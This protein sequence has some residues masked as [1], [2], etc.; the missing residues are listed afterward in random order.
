VPVLITFEG[1]EGAGKSTLIRGLS[2]RLRMQGHEVVV[3][4]EPGAGEVGRRIREILLHGPKL[5]P[6]AEVLLFLAD[7]AE[8]CATVIGPAL[9]EC[10]IVLCDR[11]AD[12]TVVYQGHARGLD[13]EMLR[14]WNQAATQGTVPALTILLDLPAEEGLKRLSN[15]DRLDAEPLE[16][17]QKVRQGFLEESKREPGRWAVL[18]AS[19]APEVLLEQASALINDRLRGRDVRLG[20]TGGH[21]R[22]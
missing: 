9:K 11:F 19:Q 10:K 4:R 3:T 13:L 17:H 12:S 16:F 5:H 1:P 20:A 2:S 21:K 6:I 8:H 14:A 18:D 7:R 15:K 22:P